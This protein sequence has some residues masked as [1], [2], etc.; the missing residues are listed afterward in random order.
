MDIREDGLD[1]AHARTFEWF[2]KNPIPP[3]PSVAPLRQWVRSKESIFW[4]S[5]KAG[6]GKSTLMKYTVTAPGMSKMLDDEFP[7]KNRIVASHYLYER[8]KDPLQKSK[9][10]LLRHL[11]YHLITQDRALAKP[12]FKHL[13]AVRYFD[14]ETVWSWKELK[15]ALELALGAVRPNTI[16]LL[17]IDGLDEYRAIRKL[18]SLGLDDEDEDA[19]EDLAEAI[20]DGHQEIADLLLRMARHNHVRLCVSSRPLIVFQDNFKNFRRMELHTKTSGDIKQYVSD[21]LANNPLL[22]ELT[23]EKPTFEEEVKTEILLKADGVFL[24][25]KLVMGIIIRSLRGRDTVD[26]LLSKI[27]SMPKELGGKGGLY[28]A[29]LRNISLEDRKEGFKYFQI[30]L[31]SEF[32]LDPLFVSYATD[33]ESEVYTMSMSCLGSDE[34]KARRT[35]TAERLLTRCGGLLEVKTQLEKSRFRKEYETRITVTFIHQ[36]AKEFVTKRS[37]WELLLGANIQNSFDG[38]L[39]LQRAAVILLK[40]SKPLH[41][42]RTE[43]ESCTIWDRLLFCLDCAS[44]TD[45]SSRDASAKL[46]LLADRVMFN[47]YRPQELC[48]YNLTDYSTQNL[49]RS[50]RNEGQEPSLQELSSH[51]TPCKT[52]LNMISSLRPHHW[53]V[54]DPYA[55]DIPKH[56]SLMAVAVQSNLSSFLDV[57][58]QGG[59]ITITSPQEYPLLAYGVVPFRVDYSIIDSDSRLGINQCEPEITVLLLQAGEDPNQQYSGPAYY[60]DCTVWQGVLVYGDLLYETCVWKQGPAGKEGNFDK[61]GKWVENAK[62]LLNWGADANATCP[63]TDQELLLVSYEQSYRHRSSLFIMTTI[64]W[65]VARSQ[66]WHK[67]ALQL[68]VDKGATLREGEREDLLTLAEILKIPQPLIRSFS[69]IVLEGTVIGDNAGATLSPRASERYKV[70]KRLR[71]LF[72]H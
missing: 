15:T 20:T 58:S 66:G 29:M 43:E 32:E 62:L 18:E 64:L 31:K 65:R 41:E 46:V 22:A 47:L 36:T 45:Q 21:Q 50:D 25:V 67:D 9:E 68:M 24:W 1:D 48:D 34:M 69:E 35:R 54:L 28:M 56:K 3:D 30:L 49:F 37:N 42:G 19:D 57:M 27:R 4:I 40:R 2:L 6:C 12:I 17:F 38:S 53:S 44:M 11:L 39:A 23:I 51:L 63:V 72:L 55:Y 52:T 16:V 10:G 71:G 61:F 60:L 13:K 8:G 14:S 26:V 7:G 5:G 33:N 59:E 70:E